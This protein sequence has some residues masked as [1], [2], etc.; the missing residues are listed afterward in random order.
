MDNSF[1][2][3]FLKAR[4]AM[5]SGSETKRK[6]DPDKVIIREEKSDKG[7]TLMSIIEECPP[8]AKILEYLRKRIEEIEAED[9]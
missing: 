8:K 3:S 7:I 5:A 6:G 2:R 9:E 1:L 4:E